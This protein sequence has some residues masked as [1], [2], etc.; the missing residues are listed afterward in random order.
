MTPSSPSD[1]TPAGFSG[2]IYTAV[3]A[4]LFSAGLVV[5]LA[6][7][8]LREQMTWLVPAVVALSLVAALPVSWWLVPR[9]RTWVPDDISPH[10]GHRAARPR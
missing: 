10:S 9:L 8:A 4:V 5:V 6:I 1:N 7:P 3:N 2:V